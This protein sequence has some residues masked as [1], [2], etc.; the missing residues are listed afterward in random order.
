MKTAI[1]AISTVSDRK[2]ATWAK[3]YFF[4][5]NGEPWGGPPSWSRCVRAF[6]DYVA[7]LA[8]IARAMRDP[9]APGAAEKIYEAFSGE[10]MGDERP[11]GDCDVWYYAQVFQWAAAGFPAETLRE[12]EAER[13]ED[14]AARARA[15]GVQ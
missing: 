6:D 13:E 10:V 1:K 15:G 11:V 5:R 4:A 8:E 9:L 12:L 3:T 2:A 7:S 14:T